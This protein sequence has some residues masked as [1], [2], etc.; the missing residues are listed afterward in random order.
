MIKIIS[1]K[2]R[3]YDRIYDCYECPYNQNYNQS[4]EC[5]WNIW[6]DE[7]PKTIPE[8]CPLEDE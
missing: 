5:F 4:K 7:C 3:K 1:L 8:N 2:N 6:K